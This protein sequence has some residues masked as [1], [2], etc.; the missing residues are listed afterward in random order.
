MKTVSPIT[1]SSLPIGTHFWA[2]IDREYL[3]LF[4]MGDDEFYCAGP[5]ECQF[6]EED[7]YIIDIVKN[8]NGVELENLYYKPA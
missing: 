2:K 6:R 3:I 7:F 4:K 5:W 8:P 1:A